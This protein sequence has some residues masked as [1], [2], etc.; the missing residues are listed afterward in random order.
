MVVIVEIGTE[1][2]VVTMN[3]L[4]TGVMSRITIGIMTEVLGRI[5]K[6]I[7]KIEEIIGIVMDIMIA[8]KMID[9]IIN[10][11]EMI[12]EI[13]IGVK[14]MK[15]IIDVNVKEMKTIIVVT[16]EK[17]MATVEN[18]TI[19]EIETIRISI[20]MIHIKKISVDHRA[21]VVT[22]DLMIIKEI[23]L[24]SMSR[25]NVN[26][27]GAEAEAAAVIVV[28]IIGAPKATKKS[29]PR[30]NNKHMTK[31]VATNPLRT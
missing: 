30:V 24:Y 6:P 5:E 19:D 23:I 11:V 4:M 8:E 26:P 2:I 28:Q 17:D 12:Q 7:E 10:H 13:M 20:K 14:E 9:M 18:E 3:G 27:A 31:M 25:V 1:T 22:I 15:T 21:E 29:T 16:L